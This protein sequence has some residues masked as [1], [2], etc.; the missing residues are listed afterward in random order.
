MANNGG[1]SGDVVIRLR[2]DT[3]QAEAD[4]KRLRSEIGAASVVTGRMTGGGGGYGPGGGGG[5]GLNIGGMLAGAAGAGLLGSFGPTDFARGVGTSALGLG[6]TYSERSGMADYRRRA[7]APGEATRR[8]VDQLGIAGNVAS[9]AQIRALRDFNSSM[10]SAQ[11]EA[12]KR[13]R[14]VSGG[15]QAKEYEAL[16]MEALQMFVKHWPAVAGALIG[17]KWGKYGG[18]AGAV[19]GEVVTAVSG[20]D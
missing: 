19:I 12:E 8:T 5:G 15:D 20:R 3:A 9:E 4:L 2:L 11:N 14:Q 1:S 18:I 7:N 16:L 13:V 17:S 6:A 10:L